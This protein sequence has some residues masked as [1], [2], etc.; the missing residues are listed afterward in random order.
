MSYL[1]INKKM[2]YFLESDLSLENPFNSIPDILLWLQESKQSNHVIINEIKFSEMKQWFFDQ[3]SGNYRHISGGFFSIDGIEVKTNYGS[4][5]AWKQPI[6]NQ[7]ELGILGIVTKKIDGKLYFLMQAKIEPGNINTVQLSP[8]L[9]ATKSN[10]TQKHKGKKPLYLEYFLDTQKIVLF[11]QLQS[12]QG[13]RFLQKRN[14][15][16]I[17]QVNSDIPIY[18]NYRWLTLGQIKAL[19]KYDNLVNMDTRTILSGI[20]YCNRN[21]VNQFISSVSD[22]FKI[23]MLYSEISTNTYISMDGFIAWFT[24]LKSLFDLS[25]SKIRLDDIPEWQ[26]TDDKIHHIENKF[27]EVIPVK[28]QIEKREVLS[29]DQPMVR[30]CQQGICAFIIKKIDGIYHFLVQAKVECGNF[31]IVE[32]APTVQ[33]LTGSYKSGNVYFLKDVLDALKNPQKVKFNTIQS[34]EGGRFFRESNRNIIV[35]VGDKFSLDVPINFNWLSMGQLKNLIRF[36]NYVNIQ[37][38]SLLSLI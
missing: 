5:P 29:W 27:F 19:L 23:D 16:I 11:D 26:L 31:D 20:R 28:V 9:Q 12:E 1:E 36:N 14:R 15:N 21:I 18:E 22:Q 25:V 35:E 17:I 24:E 32:I 37:A 38:R 7:P 6:I 30:P 3:S 10:Y 34:E 2:H 13:A 8:T 4:V 33:C